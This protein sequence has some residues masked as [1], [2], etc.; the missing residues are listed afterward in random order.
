MSRFSSV[1]FLYH[2]SLCLTISLK[3]LIYKYDALEHI[4]F[5]FNDFGGLVHLF[6]CHRVNHD[7]SLNAEWFELARNLGKNVFKV[8]IRH[9]QI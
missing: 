3:M 4:G 6:I 9:K 8:D 2:S 5:F 7:I 1:E